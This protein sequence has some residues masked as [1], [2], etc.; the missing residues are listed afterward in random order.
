MYNICNVCCNCAVLEV[1][2]AS[3]CLYEIE[4]GVV[5]VMVMGGGRSSMWR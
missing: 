4:K 2:G 3:V 1:P 5:V